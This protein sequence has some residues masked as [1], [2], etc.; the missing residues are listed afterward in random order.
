[1]NLRVIGAA[2][3]PI[4]LLAPGAALASG[5]RHAV[6]TQHGWISGT[7]VS[8]SPGHWGRRTGFSPLHPAPIVPARA[9]V[10]SRVT[11]GIGTT[12]IYRLGAR[13]Y[14]VTYFPSGRYS[15]VINL[16]PVGTSLAPLN[17][18]APVRVAPVVSLRRAAIV[19]ARAVIVSRF[20]NGTTTTVT[21][22]LGIRY[23]HVTYFPNGHYTYIINLSPAAMVVP[24]TVN[25]APAATTSSN[26][27][28]LSPVVE[29]AVPVS[30][31]S[32]M[33]RAG[34]G[35]GSGVPMLPALLGLGLTTLGVLLRRWYKVSG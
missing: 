28:R 22:R 30:G 27:G 12:V 7:T 33:P 9:V 6:Q 25:Q 31:I 8:H 5:A 18:V 1:M 17:R 11:S 23:Y 34:G 16:S 32:V 3:F 13:F 20:S 2:L 14:H 26:T 4:A 24:S 35:D 15:Y 19:P 10:T 21:Y 29:P